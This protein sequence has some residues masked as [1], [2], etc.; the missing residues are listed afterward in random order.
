MDISKVSLIGADVGGP[1][2]E[3]NCEKSGIPVTRVHIDGDL[4]DL[5]DADLLIDQFY[6]DP[7]AKSRIVRIVEATISE[8]AIFASNPLFSSLTQIASLFKKRDRVIGLLPPFYS[9]ISNFS[10]IVIGLETSEET[11]QSLEAFL[12]KIG[13][14][15]SKSKD[16]PG[17][18]LNRVLASMINEAIH[19]YSYGL[20][21]MES[22]DQM[23][24]LAANFPMGP[25]EYA[26]EIGLDN[27]LNVLTL[28][29]KEL[30][31]KYRPS[32][33]L[34]RKVEAGHL[35]KKSGI[36]FYEYRAK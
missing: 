19:V 10:E 4:K 16:S 3:Q 29:M 11:S 32:P 35:G 21:P 6:G 1:L 24:K 13:I 31:P 7:D 36:G 18:V 25:L 14:A 17:F 2:I 28:L 26:D 9:G 22:I 23:M 5:R 20:A 27:I 34:I 8:K 15:C 12:G 30:G 33:L